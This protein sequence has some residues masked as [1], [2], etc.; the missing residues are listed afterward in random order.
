VHGFDNHLCS[1]TRNIAQ[2]CIIVA[3]VLDVAGV[4]EV[5]GDL[6]VDC[7]IIYELACRLQYVQLLPRLLHNGRPRGPLVHVFPRL[8]ALVAAHCNSKESFKGRYEQLSSKSNS[9][10]LVT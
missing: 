3:G 7:F 10:G 4:L 2:H 8:T 6:Q 1:L 5:A 9:P